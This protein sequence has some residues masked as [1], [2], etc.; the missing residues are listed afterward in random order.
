MRPHARLLPFA[1][2]L[3]VPLRLSTGILSERRGWLLRLEDADGRVGW[4]EC[5][6]FPGL[7]RESLDDAHASLDAWT[8]DR[9]DAALLPSARAAVDGARLD[10]TAQAS[11]VSM[12]RALNSGATVRVDLAVLLAGDDA[13]VVVRASEAT[14]QGYRAA[15]LKVGAATVDADAR[16]VRA[17]ARELG[18][19]VALRLDANRA[20]GYDEARRFADAIAGVSLAFIEEPLA[21]ATRLPDLARETGLAI[22]LDESIA[23]MASPGD[24]A[25][26]AYAAAAVLKPLVLGGVGAALGWGQAAH[27]CGL[28]PVVS[29]AF[30]TGVG[31]RHALALAAALGASGPSA[32]AGLDP[33]TYLASDVLTPRLSLDV[34][35]VDV[36]AALGSR[37]VVRDLGPYTP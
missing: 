15:K 7:S 4:G 33:Y 12:A 5:A 24:L 32:P 27:R 26:H 11:D 3:R 16:R 2:P 22:A 34:S 6:P 28:V 9:D 35:S 8:R 18:S 19:G 31:T 20:W 13:A 21:D 36:E 25:T 14:H 29:S 37:H 1:I 30:E 23:A 10:L 17:V